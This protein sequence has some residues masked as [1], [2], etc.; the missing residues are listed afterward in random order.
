MKVHKNIKN[1]ISC[2]LISIA[3]GA[4]LSCQKGFLDRY[5]QNAIAPSQFF[6]TEQDLSLYINGLLSL[7]GTGTYL[8]DQSSDNLATT[9]AIELKTIMEGTPT[10]QNITG[11]WSWGRLRDIN[12]FLDNCNKASVD[13][14]TKY[15]YVGLARYYRAMF[16]F[17]MVRRY[18]DVPW[19]SHTLNPSDSSLNR[20]RD[21]RALV[22]DSVM[23]DLNFAAS[24]VRTSVATGTPGQW[25]VKLFYARVALYE[26]TYRK[27]HSE[28]QLQNTASAFLQKARDIAADI[29]AN[30]NF[31][32]YNTGNPSQDYAT[33]FSS[34]DLTT[35]KEVI[36]T[37]VYD[38]VK[39]RNGNVNTVVFG[40][41]EQSPSRDLVQTYLMSDGTR[42]TDQAGY[43]QFSFVQEFQGRDPR[44]RQTIVYPG[45]VKL[46]NT[47]PYVQVLSSNFTGY[48]QLKGYINST[49]PNIIGG[50]DYPVYRY[51]EALLIYAEAQAELGAI[52]QSDLDKSV[53]LLRSRAGLPAMNLVAAN[54]NPDP[55]L[56]TA[57]PA[58]SGANTGVLLE[59]R[60]ERRVELAMEGF[61]YDDLMRW[62]AG[63]LLINIPQGMYFPG[64]GKF[65]LTGDGI[66]D[67]QLIDKNTQ[68]PSTKDT[69]SLGVQLIYYQAGT[70]NDNVTVAL[71]NGTSGGPIIT[72]SA[73]RQFINPKYYYRPVPATEVLLN[74]NLKQIFGW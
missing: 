9:G 64:L 72:E 48:H 10:A 69:N 34:Q 42:F 46:P 44:L 36:L 7:P 19:Y 51:A 24:H 28:L 23:S 13:T 56:M 8:S 61:R 5:P 29:M 45:W 14:A 50:A 12:Y 15:H 62:D 41:Y 49:D 52:T 55:V 31:G 11:G 58:V 71:Q 60:R 65:D 59:I 39:K 16:Y 17:G 37:D 73:T 66:P 32:I 20:P 33:L 40:N 63:N 35:N 67:I 26:G 38:V 57:Y 18:S 3:L 22:M 1:S 25:A 30:G 43:Q 4:T 47:K 53:N 6:N 68:I 70:I 74:P 2:L 21:P 54:G 27:Y